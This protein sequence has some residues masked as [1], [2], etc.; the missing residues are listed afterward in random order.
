MR[1]ATKIALMV[2]IAA[3]VAGALPANVRVQQAEGVVQYRLPDAAQWESLAPGQELPQGTTIISGSN[4]SAILA[5]G[6]ST[7]EVDALS[8]IVLNEVTLNAGQETTDVEMRFGQVR[9]RV[10]RSQNRGTDFRV[11]TPVSTAA[12]RGTDFVY[13][14]REL[15]VLEGDVA[16]TNLTGQHHSVRAG[17]TSRTWKHLDIE[18]V[19]RTVIDRLSF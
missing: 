13:D 5:S 18:S 2:V 6:D 7:I 14:G 12:V 9:S 16:F 4:G 11:S 3:V 17:Q 15:V 8:R 19:E 10:R 1:Y